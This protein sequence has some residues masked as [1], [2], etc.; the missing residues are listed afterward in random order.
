MTALDYAIVG[1]G[2]NALAAGAV[3]AKAGKKVALFEREA[4]AG[5]CVRTEELA[6]GYLYDPLATTFVLWV[7]GGAHAKLA[8]DLERHG[9]EFCTTQTPTGALLPN[10]KALT[11]ST[12]RATN[13]AAFNAASAGDGD[14]LSSDLDAFAQDADLLFGLMGGDPWSLQTASMLGKQAWKRGPRNLAARFGEALQP[15][16]GWLETSFDSELSRALWAPWGL[17]AGLPPEASFS[18]QMG[19]IIG[20]ALEAAGAPIVKGGA[21]KMVEALSAIIRENGGVVHLS[22]PVE[23][24]TVK[25]GKAT[26]LRLRSGQE[27]KAGGV[28]A[29]VTPNQL[30]GSLVDMPERKENLRK[31]RY[32]RGNFQLHYALKEA[33]E[34]ATEGL[35][36]VQLLHLTSGLDGVSKASNEA[37]RGL[38]PDMPTICVGQ[39]SVAD[40]SRAPEGGAVLWLQIPDTPRVIKGDAAGQIATPDD[41]S[42]DNEVREAFADRVEELLAAHIPNLKQNVVARKALSPS[43]LQGMNMNLVGGDPYGGACSIDQFFAFRP[44]PDSK[45]HS[46][47][48]KNLWQI[49]AS[50]HPGPGLSGGSGLLVAEEILG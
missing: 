23:Q 37:E 6:P 48:V 10:G 22:A 39:P 38:L 4:V 40:P 21:G 25:N 2:I 18:G 42:W 35:D 8:G 20:F 24:V 33:P 49:G 50:T 9:V 11:Y 19:Q 47:G 30:Y 27:I 3:L 31:Y 36:E 16:R 34:W 46:T 1:S 12:D 17:H 5:G 14:R 45:R 43:D 44:F 41:G 28:L 29:S 32:G 13:V 15:M 26:G 7:T